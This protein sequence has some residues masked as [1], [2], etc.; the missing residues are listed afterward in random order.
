MSALG[1]TIRKCFY[2]MCTSF[3]HLL[4]CK[5]I[6][7]LIFGLKMSTFPFYTIIGIKTYPTI[8]VSDFEHYINNFH[9]TISHKFC[10]CQELTWR[11]KKSFTLYDLVMRKV[12]KKESTNKI[13]TLPNIATQCRHNY[14]LSNIFDFIHEIL[15]TLP[16]L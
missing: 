8:N 5:V 6:F 4:Y 1:C 16:I 11:K 10:S 12:E 14:H 3:V 15:G 9:N 2:F 13:E 7:I